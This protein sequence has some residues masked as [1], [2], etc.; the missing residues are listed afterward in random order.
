MTCDVTGM[1]LSK[2]NHPEMSKHLTQP[3]SLTGSATEQV[4]KAISA[5]AL[6]YFQSLASNIFEDKE[7]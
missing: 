2:L 5:I 1:M 7:P 6:L 3:T 4:V